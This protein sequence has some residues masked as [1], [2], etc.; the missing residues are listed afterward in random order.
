VLAGCNTQWA[1]DQLAALL[2]PTSFS[3]ALLPRQLL[4]ATLQKRLGQKLGPPRA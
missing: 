2:S 3:A 1:E 4:H